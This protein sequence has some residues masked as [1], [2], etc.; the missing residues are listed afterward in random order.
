M[1][2]LLED[3]TVI[4]CASYIAGPAAATILSDFGARVI[5]IEPPE[6]GDSYR[7]LLRL[8]GLPE[9]DENYPWILT[10]RNKESLAIDLKHNKAQEI[11][12]QL[13]SKADIFITNYPFPIRDRLKIT[14]NDMMS[15]N[16]KLIYA[17]LSPYGEKGEE[18]DRTGYDATAWWARSG[19]MHAIRGDSDAV[20]NSPAPGMGDHPTASALFGSIMM[21]LYKREI[22]GEGSEVSSS[23][24]AN[25]LWSNGIFVQA[26]LCGANFI[27]NDGRGIKGA[28]AEKYKCKDGRWFI[29]VMLNE[30]RE[31]PLLLKC[32]N[33]EDL[34][35]DI[36]FNSR[37]NRAKNSLDLVEILDKEFIKKDWS[38]LQ[39]LFQKSGVTYGPI[40]EP[41]DHIEDKQI[42]DNNFF[43]SY[44]DR[45][46]L[47]TIDSPVYMK[48]ETKK[49]PKLA[50]SIGQH[51]KEIL[52]ELNYNEKEIKDFET[53]KMIKT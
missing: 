48:G 9:S 40:S 21:A 25:G 34:N 23:L 13:V 53:K 47:L 42:R 28:L 2:H 49:E 26:A 33:R 51:T 18:K 38:D 3:I 22:Y 17:S 30:E 44:S 15:L 37:E 11:L 32:I 16:S 7:G 24:L 39:L 6:A 1:D 35:E 46:D 19:L 31:W 29:L 10:S 5:K 52:L 8:P 20:P 36:R 12:H 43:R 27:N 14:A 45:Q 41:T 50:P 4:D